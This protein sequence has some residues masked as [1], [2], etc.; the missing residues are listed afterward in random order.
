MTITD[1]ECMTDAWG[2][3]PGAGR[4]TSAETSAAVGGIAMVMVEPPP[5]ELL[6]MPGPAVRCGVD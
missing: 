1:R 2:E 6:G 3:V 5:P 4:G